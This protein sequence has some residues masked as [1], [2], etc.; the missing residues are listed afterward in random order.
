MSQRTGLRAVIVG[1]LLA[2]LA[3]AAPAAAQVKVGDFITAAKADKDDLL[4][5]QGWERDGHRNRY[6]E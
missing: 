6:H 3:T 4:L 1:L 5:W 2:V